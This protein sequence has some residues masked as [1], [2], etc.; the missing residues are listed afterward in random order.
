MDRRRAITNP[1]RPWLVF[2]RL[3]TSVRATRDLGPRISAPF[4]AMGICA[5]VASACAASPEERV[6][7]G[8]AA[9]RQG[10]TVRSD[11]EN[12][13]Q[14]SSGWS[15]RDPKRRLLTATDAEPLIE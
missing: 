3:A 11:A 13:T 10:K 6:G 5:K 12:K 14:R 15:D 4:N 1:T 2:S 8:L 7:A 9:R